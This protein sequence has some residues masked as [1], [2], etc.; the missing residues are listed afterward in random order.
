M[1]TELPFPTISLQLLLW[2][3]YY[4]LAA[5]AVMRNDMELNKHLWKL[6]RKGQGRRVSGLRGEVKGQ[7]GR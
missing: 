4:C 1:N 5:A 6:I 3:P 2:F 7:I